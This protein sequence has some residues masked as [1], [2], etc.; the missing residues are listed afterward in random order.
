MHVQ[1]MK[2]SEELNSAPHPMFSMGARRHYPEKLS[3]NFEYR[4]HLHCVGPTD[5]SK[6]KPH[7]GMKKIVENYVIVKP[8]VERIGGHEDFEKLINGKEI[9]QKYNG[10]KQ[11][12]AKQKVAEKRAEDRLKKTFSK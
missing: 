8:K 10:F 11:I 7:V 3:K 4:P 2:T 1:P 5:H 9:M 12:Q 6:D